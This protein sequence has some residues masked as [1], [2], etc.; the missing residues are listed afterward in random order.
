MEMYADKDGEKNNKNKQSQSESDD[1][2]DS[3]SSSGSNSEESSKSSKNDEDMRDESNQETVQIEVPLSVIQRFF[4]SR[5]AVDKYL[6]Q[7]NQETTFEMLED[8]CKTY[9]FDE[10]KT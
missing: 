2:E 6:N 1:E 3:S 9:K 7:I 10:E 5:E 8:L 4:A